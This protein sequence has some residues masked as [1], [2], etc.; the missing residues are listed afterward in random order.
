MELGAQ[1]LATHFLSVLATEQ[2]LPAMCQPQQRDTAD[3]PAHHGLFH[4]MLNP[5]ELGE[6]SAESHVG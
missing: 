5:P 3:T 4:S 2:S 6:G 1:D